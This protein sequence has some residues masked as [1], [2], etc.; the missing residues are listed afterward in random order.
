MFEGEFLNDKIHG[1]GKVYYNDELRYDGE[2]LYGHNTKGKF[3]YNGK[4]EYEGELR[5]G[6]KWNGKGYD[7]KGNIIYELINGTGKVKEYDAY[8]ILIF[9]GEYLNGK[10]NGKGK[11][12]YNG[13]LVFEGEYLYDI[14][15]GKGKE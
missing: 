1:K 11:E 12:Y 7:E 15:N 5:Y 4:L 3:Y 2:Y 9:E 8:G 13:K 10:R 6:C 14:R